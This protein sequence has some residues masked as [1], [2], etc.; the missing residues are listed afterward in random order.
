MI[1]AEL[2]GF[3]DIEERIKPEWP[4]M[5]REET[6]RVVRH[7]PSGVGPARDSGFITYSTLDEGCADHVIQEQIQHFSGLGLSFEWK[8]FGHDDPPD[9]GAR[10]IAQGFEQQDPESI[11]VLDLN[12]VPDKLIAPVDN[13]VR[14]VGDPPS[15]RDLRTLIEQVWK[16]TSHDLFADLAYTLGNHPETL[17]V[18]VAYCDD[19]PVS[20]AWL[21]I[22]DSRPFASLWGGSTLPEYRREGYYTALVA[23]RVQE[24]MT[25][26]AQF[27]TVDAG[28]M[29]RPIVERLGFREITTACDYNH[30]LENRTAAQLD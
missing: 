7:R 11:M 9:L 3:Y 12:E 6:P 19:A 16:E 30:S 20:V 24:A 28:P 21:R 14:Q 29:S 26:G 23:T 25:R 18:Y 8:V 27:V 15:L 10:L 2:R 1:D 22:S 4:P 5:I 13:D 17:S